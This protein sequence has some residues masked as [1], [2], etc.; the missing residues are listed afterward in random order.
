MAEV[1]LTA[2]TR[3]V[4]R[5]S[6]KELAFISTF[7]EVNDGLLHLSGAHNCFF[8]RY[9]MVAGGVIRYSQSMLM[10]SVVEPYSHR[11]LQSFNLLSFSLKKALFH[12]A[13]ASSTTKTI[14]LPFSYE[15]FCYL[16]FRLVASPD[17]VIYHLDR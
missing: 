13:Q 8:V 5:E 14:R 15:S 9:Q 11:V 6:I 10:Q 7:A 2:T 4:S 3:A 16:I 1:I 17:I 12:Q